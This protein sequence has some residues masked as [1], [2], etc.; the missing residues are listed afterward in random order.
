MSNTRTM[1]GYGRASS[2]PA[3]RTKKSVH[4]CPAAMMPQSMKSSKVP[5]TRR[6]TILASF[7]SPL[8]CSLGFS[9]SGGF[10]SVSV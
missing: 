6:L 4:R 7:L 9:F 10:S 1:R 3:V 8:L 2:K 5:N